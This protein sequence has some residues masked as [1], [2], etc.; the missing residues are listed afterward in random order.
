M[1]KHIQCWIAFDHLDNPVAIGFTP[2][3]AAS[4]AVI[5]NK[6]MKDWVSLAASGWKL[7]KGTFI[8]I[9]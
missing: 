2:P 4:K 6:P 5:K 7:V 3:E 8:P 1:E 9:K